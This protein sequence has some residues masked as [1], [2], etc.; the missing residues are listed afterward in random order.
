MSEKERPPSS[1][2][3]CCERRSHGKSSDVET[4]TYG[5]LVYFTQTHTY[6]LTSMA[7]VNKAC[8]HSN[9]YVTCCAINSQFTDHCQNAAAILRRCMSVWQTDAS[10]GMAWAVRHSYTTRLL[11]TMTLS[12][13][14]NNCWAVQGNGLH[15][16]AR[17]PCSSLGLQLTKE[18]DLL[19]CMCTT[20]AKR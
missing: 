8:Q 3:C 17:P 9:C 12:Y 7:A 13:I 20:A 14:T 4:R 11:V 6:N 2:L 10:L 1:S 19:V 16:Q 5:S 15:S 18:A